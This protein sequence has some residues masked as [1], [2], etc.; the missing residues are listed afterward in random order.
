[1]TLNGLSNGRI[2]QRGPGGVFVAT[3]MTGIDAWGWGA[4]QRDRR[5]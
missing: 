4:L 1:M 3:G 2:R 5:M